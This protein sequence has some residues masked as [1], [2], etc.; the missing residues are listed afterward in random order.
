MPFL[1]YLL[2]FVVVGRKTTAIKRQVQITIKI[3]GKNLTFPFLV[4]PDLS[5]DIIVGIDWIEKH[6]GFIGLEKNALN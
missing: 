6:G 2:I 4:V 5:V 3:N 1:S